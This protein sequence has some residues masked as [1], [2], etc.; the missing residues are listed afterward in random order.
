MR[1]AWDI[2][3]AFV[4]VVLL[5][6]VL[7]PTAVYVLLSTEPIQCKIR[8]VA[9]QELTK[10]LGAD[11]SIDRISIHPFN[12]IG[13]EGIAVT[14]PDSTVPAS[15]DRLRAGI[16]LRHLLRTG[17]FVVDYVYIDGISV[18]VSRTDSVSPLNIQPIIDHLKNDKPKDSQSSFEMRINNIVLRNGNLS[19]DVLS[20]PGPE[21]GRFDKNHIAISDFALNAY[22][23]F[24][25]KDT[26]K[27][28]I[29][30]LSFADRS[31]FE[32]T[33]AQCKTEIDST[34]ADF[35]KVIVELPYSR[36]GLEPIT[37]NYNGL[38]NIGRS[39]NNS[40]L[41][42]R[43]SANSY[44]Y[45]PDFS[46]FVPVL[47]DFD[48]RLA[49]DIDATYG[50]RNVD[51]R[52]FLI[53]DADSGSLNL[54]MAG[55]AQGLDSIEGM[56]YKLESLSLLCEG[57]EICRI[58]RGHISPKL[59]K[60]LCRIPTL[61]LN[62]KA[63]GTLAEGVFELKAGGQE[64]SVNTSGH[65]R[66]KI[67][68]TLDLQADA[69][70]KDLDIALI[71]GNTK[72]GLASASVSCDLKNIGK[73]ISGN[74]TADVEHIEYAGYGYSNLSLR[75]D[76]EE[77]QRTEISL[78]MNDPNANVLAYGFYNNID[79]AHDLKA[80][81]AV[82]SV[83][84][85]VLG[86]DK[87]H[88]DYT[89][90]FKGNI[91]MH[92]NNAD[93]IEGYLQLTD[94][95]WTDFHGTGLRVNRFNVGISREGKNTD[96][97]ID[98]DIIKGD[99]KGQCAFSQLPM[100][101]TGLISKF[102]PAVVATPEHAPA[103]PNIFQYD[104]I[105]L[106]SPKVTEF[107]GI[108]VNIIHDAQL[109]GYVDTDK[110]KA[111]MELDAPFLSH[112][113]KLIE[114][115]V[116]YANLDTAT[117]KSTIYLTTQ[118]PTNKGD[119][120][121]TGIVQAFDNQIDTRADWLIQRRIPLN[122]SLSFSARL[123]NR[124][125][126]YP[127]QALLPFPLSLDFNPGT[128]NFG[129]ETW[130][131][132]PSHIHLFGNDITVEGFGLSADSQSIDI[133]GAISK[134]P[135][136][137][138]TI[139]LNKISLLPIF[140]TL[141]INKALISG[142]ASGKF[143]AHDVLSETPALRCERLHVD[144]IGYNR[145][146]IGDA[147]IVTGWNNDKKSFYFDADIT[148]PE[149]NG[150]RIDGDIFPFTEALD[151][152]FHANH[153]PVGFL[154]PFMD[155]FTSDI[156]G[157]A[158]GNCRLF[159]TFKEIDLEGTV[160]ADDVKIKIDFINAYYTAT[161]SVRMTPG[162]I[163]LDDITIH[164]S[165]GHTAI[166]NG[167]VHHTYFKEP[168]F[169]FDISDARD[170]M[171]FNGTSK[172]NPDWYGT[173]YGNGSASVSGYPGVV[174]ISANMSTAPRSTFTFVL[175][176][177]LDAESYSFINFRDATPDSIK[178]ANMPV[179]N[180]P[181]LV[182]QLKDKLLAEQNDE[183]SAYNMDIRVDITKDAT[184]ILVMDPVG[185]DDIKAVGEGNMRLV[186][187]ST[188]NNLNIWGSYKVISGSYRFTLQDIIIRDFTIK[189][190]SEIRF[191][192]DPYAVK[193]D[194][195]AYYATTA[196]LTDLDE[197]FAM[198][199]DISRTNVPVHALMFVSGVITQPEIK[200]DLEFPTL[201]QDTYRK[202]RSIISTEDMM[203][204]QIIYL[205]ALN[206]FYTPDYM[207]EKTKGSELFSVAS[208]TISSQLGNMLGKLSDNWSIAPNLR[209]D[210]GD[211]SDVEV[212]VALSSRLLNNRLLFNGNFGYRDK[213]LN[214]NQ[215]I[216]DFDIEYLLNK[217][218]SW[219][220]K[221]Y[222][223]YNDRNYYVRSAQTTQGVGIMFRRDFD[224]FLSFL[225]HFRKHGKKNDNDSIR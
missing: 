125:T 182:R 22:L 159:G 158:S 174:N 205:L 13:L 140:E 218:G 92:G 176:D 110:G 161:D 100:A 47:G 61:G 23:P 192:G 167:V 95:R 72:L 145:C 106:P 129:D 204:R 141:E 63:S 175:S 151:I 149:K 70:I 77:N 203:N 101:F 177:R 28:E 142:R 185:G 21:E 209:S 138:L 214:T 32:L 183:P 197:S 122:G 119:M 6:A 113:D 56:N 62:L 166:L 186:Y 109:S 75:A 223:R 139:D 132:K 164:D 54:S 76:I 199:K 5:L 8:D 111:T 120:A 118:F 98:S 10:L 135:E 78:N 117:A 73:N 17:E 171:A 146:T 168:V 66:R 51:I 143:I 82:S 114:G 220:L 20:S 115:T 200:F 30:H 12:R 184:M 18:R 219:R 207:A 187:E 217:R 173:I 83:D 33:H 127:A 69:E 124:P 86:F 85:N 49:L 148:G 144:S 94:I 91:D 154:K 27:V 96:V 160:F 206:R 64:G 25:G 165:E 216:G 181:E 68:K 55:Y 170:F 188:D 194:L 128:I 42:I 7:I 24:I 196:N 147:D 104:F 39:L 14:L 19:Y 198:D 213:S 37:L 44:I 157:Y 155:A 190:G 202:A 81:I 3:R 53:K 103:R 97:A 11:V 26:Y 89:F 90:G 193:T 112:G 180:T 189:E 36:I 34:S 105:L 210:R 116:V 52:R 208:S 1:R 150:S 67:N 93:D 121:L 99:I 134:N 225:K 130:S 60:P 108:P 50:L 31:G 40:D 195:T 43:T 41:P 123:Q 35:D 48:I 172:Q 126:D 221:A 211:F 15:V 65:Y 215:F 45:P 107:F 79:N 222:N 2:F 88:E 57:Y 80:T 137:V 59:S 58:L 201:T 84:F 191:D 74:I 133:D 156:S 131:I 4:S 102:L 71:T 212:D 38:G 224:D 29:D 152:N 9:T 162:K 87:K 178:R 136:D 169:K 46:A 179:D 16:E 163:L 153:V